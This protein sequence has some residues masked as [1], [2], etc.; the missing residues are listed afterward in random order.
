MGC[1]GSRVQ[2]S[3]LRPVFQGSFPVTS[4]TIYTGHIADTLALKG[5][6]YS[7]EIGE[8]GSGINCHPSIRKGTTIPPVVPFIGKCPRSALCRLELLAHDLPYLGCGNR[9]FLL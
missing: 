5:F 2:I 7:D 9:R 3:A 4:L 6:V 1:K 8:A